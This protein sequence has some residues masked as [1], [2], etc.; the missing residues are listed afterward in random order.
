[1]KKPYTAKCHLF[2]RLDDFESFAF[3]HDQFR[4]LEMTA[5]SSSTYDAFKEKM[6]HV[7][8][9]QRGV[10]DRRVSLITIRPCVPD[11][12]DCDGGGKL[13]KKILMLIESFS[14]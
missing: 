4:S 1:M 9:R 5:A 6:A 14:V 2:G 10:F 11:S 13:R 8:L 12:H 7:Q 3:S